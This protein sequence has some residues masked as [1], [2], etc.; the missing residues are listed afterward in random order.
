MLELWK[1]SGEL[2]RIPDVPGVKADRRLD[3]RRA[4][5]R[6]WVSEFLQD[7]GRAFH[8]AHQKSARRISVTSAVRTVQYQTMLKLVNH[9]AAP[10]TGSERTSHSTG[11]TIDITK[12]PLEP[13]EIVWLR[14]WL[15]TLEAKGVIEVTEEFFQAVFHIMVFPRYSN[16][17]AVSDEN[18]GR[19]R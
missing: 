17:Q 12:L 15:L 6:P 1:R 10:A 11:A 5:V 3:E 14:V 16:V 4:W 18:E 19:E 2:V 7:L 8:I 9:N 13:E